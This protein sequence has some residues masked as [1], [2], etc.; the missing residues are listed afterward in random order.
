[1]DFQ[2]AT[3][4]IGRNVRLLMDAFFDVHSVVFNAPCERGRTPNECVDLT[5]VHKDLCGS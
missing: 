4:V 2:S 5:S 1:V 3:E